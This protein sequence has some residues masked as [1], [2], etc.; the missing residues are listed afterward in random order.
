MEF[1]SSLGGGDGLRVEETLGNGFVR[2][3][4]SE[5]ERRQAK[6]D[7]RC[8][9]DA[10]IEMLRNARDAGAQHI[11]V[12]IG[13]ESDTR[14]V[15]VVDDGVGIPHELHER[16]FDARVTSKLDSVHMDRW[17][18]H[19][20]GMA[21]FSISQ[22]A[23]EARVVVS[24]HGLGA[25]LRVVFD[26][27][28]ITERADQST[29]P[30]VVGQGSSVEVRGPKNIIRACVE[31]G[32]E[33]KDACK[34][35]VGSSSEVM[36][37]MRARI[38]PSAHA[39][40]LYSRNAMNEVRLV[41]LPA[42]AQDARQMRQVATHMGMEM[43]ERTAHRIVRGQ[44]RPLVNVCAR[45]AGKFETVSRPH[46]NTDARALKMSQAD[47]EELSKSLGREFDEVAARYYIT[48]TGEPKVRV[49]RGQI[50]VTFDY[51]DDI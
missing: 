22:N 47:R 9:E 20:R 33:A 37:T 36:A 14:T 41:E 44:I 4:V 28:A 27:Q 38:L 5:A 49:G 2:L 15:V 1:V 18:V 23:K 39:I 3:R 31:F 46:A 10:V 43:S 35:Y 12:A 32:F 50:V 29:W 34:V 45:V 7:I 42:L 40:E 8:V 30:E 16:V 11:F 17:G 19:G 51:V 48:R 13:K 26:T 25:S 6:H 21:L 24:D